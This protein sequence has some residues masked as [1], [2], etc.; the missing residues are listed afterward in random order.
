MMKP[1]EI[2]KGLGYHG[3]ELCDND[4][5]YGVYHNTGYDCASQLCGDASIFIDQLESKLNQAVEDIRL[6]GRMGAN[7]CPVCAHYNHGAGNPEKCP[8]ALKE[9]CFEWRGT[10][11]G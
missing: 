8:N 3:F 6:L 5:P 4:C 9:D 7:I 10:K 11:E 2:K 1:D